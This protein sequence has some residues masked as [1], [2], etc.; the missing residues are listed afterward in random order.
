MEGTVVQ[1]VLFEVLHHIFYFPFTLGI[2]LAAK[3][4]LKGLAARIVAKSFSQD[5]IPAI[6]TDNENFVLVIDNLIG[7]DGI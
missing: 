7:N 3:V 2:G 1:E 4:K 5:N 6:F